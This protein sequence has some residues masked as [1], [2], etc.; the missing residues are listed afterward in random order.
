MKPVWYLVFLVALGTA[1]V[2]QT[3]KQAMALSSQVTVI[4][5][6]MGG[7]CSVDF[8][9]TDLNGKGLY[10]A[11][12]HTIIRHGFMSQRKLELTAG[13][14]ADGRARFIKLSGAILPV[15]FTISNG[16]TVAK[17]TW[18]PADECNAHY[19]VAMRTTIAQPPAPSA[20]APA[21]APASPTS[22]VTEASAGAAIAQTPAPLAP[23]P[24]SASASSGSKV[25]EAS[26]GAAVAQT[27]APSAPAPAQP[28]SKVTIISADMGGKCWV[29]FRVT[30]MDGT[31]LYNAQIHAV[32]HHGF[33]SQKRLELD[34]ATSAYGRARFVNLQ[35]GLNSVT[36]TI[37]NGVD[38][39]KRTWSPGTDCQAHFDVPLRTK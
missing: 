11:R 15:T 3:Q 14:N 7:T 4:S 36:F 34:A 35:E 33:M 18:N 28:Q 17:R 5:A 24:A 32:I 25:A 20:P 27:P 26:A 39:A 19:D 1:S 22:Q 23:A 10:D 37:T 21:S 12:I 13:T 31:G 30:N 2:A 38:V 9:V 6:D 8:R 16:T 29:D